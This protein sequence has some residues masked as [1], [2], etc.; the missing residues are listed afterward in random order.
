MRSFLAGRLRGWMYRVAVLG[1]TVSSAVSAHAAPSG[2]Q[3]I[4]VFDD[5]AGPG[6]PDLTL[7]VS[8]E[9]EFSSP[10][11][12]TVANPT[13]GSLLQVENG[14]VYVS[15]EAGP[16]GHPIT[17][18]RLDGQPFALFGFDGAEAFLDDVES[19]LAGFPNA[20]AIRV[21]AELTAGGTYVATFNLDGIK[22][23]AGGVADF[24]TFTLPP[25]FCNI[26]SATFIGQIAPGNR[27][28]SAIDNVRV[29]LPIPE[30]SG[31]TL[32]GVAAALLAARI[33]SRRRAVWAI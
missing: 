26:T 23:G 6:N 7:L 24:Q 29:G 1:L 15:E 4:I 17:I 31:M 30:P 10:R 25:E 19:E 32:V 22:D 27:G 8:G 11:F 13:G 16:L 21:E 9:F 2:G 3:Q 14:T 33:F 5:V 20:T 18:A 28:A 12:H